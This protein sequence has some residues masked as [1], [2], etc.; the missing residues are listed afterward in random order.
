MPKIK[1]YICPHC[2]KEQEV[3]IYTSAKGYIIS[4]T[5]SCGA[6]TIVIIRRK[7]EIKTSDNNVFN[8]NVGKP[9]F[10]ESPEFE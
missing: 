2:R 8:G 9:F 1:N 4:F 10:C 5:C 7:E 6:E 3:E